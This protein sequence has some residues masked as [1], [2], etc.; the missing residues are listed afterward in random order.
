[1][2]GID[3]CVLQEI[4][5]E[6]AT[7]PKILNTPKHAPKN[8]NFLLNK[9]STTRKRF[10][11]PI[12]QSV[13]TQPQPKMES[14]L[15]RY[16][17][18]H[19]IPSAT[20]MKSNHVIESVFTTCS[21]IAKARENSPN[22]NK[23][24]ERR[25]KEM[26]I[27]PVN[28]KAVVKRS[29][30]DIFKVF[31]CNEDQPLHSY[32]ENK[33]I[34]FNQ[35]TI[36][37]NLQLLSNTTNQV[38]KSDSKLLF[39]HS[40]SMAKQ[41]NY[42]LSSAGKVV[43]SK[44]DDEPVTSSNKEVECGTQFETVDYFE[45]FGEDVADERFPDLA[46]DVRDSVT[47]NE[48]EDLVLKADENQQINVDSYS[49]FEPRAKNIHGSDFLPYI[50][51]TNAINSDETFSTSFDVVKRKL[52]KP[53]VTDKNAL[54]IEKQVIHSHKEKE[55]PKNTDFNIHISNLLDNDD[56]DLM[57]LLEEPENTNPNKRQKTG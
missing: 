41:R 4:S 44:P 43:G 29:I 57:K 8:D 22:R 14:I 52:L 10:I 20:H 7:A 28:H 49:A 18:S 37:S 2:Q 25:F 21:Q 46:T 55:S 17:D 1:M 16:Q 24:D 13:Q 3:A 6:S 47:E 56:T 19:A 15:S 34:D 23:K 31:G 12:R 11:P 35:N 50:P 45:M 9:T 54:M 53:N 32:N 5:G 33:N 42:H 48:L 27:V 38:T 51:D 26:E 36:N 40:N 30:S 39:T